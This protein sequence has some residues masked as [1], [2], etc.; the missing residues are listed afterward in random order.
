MLPQMDLSFYEKKK[1]K[2]NGAWLSRG[3]II[4]KKMAGKIDLLI[5]VYPY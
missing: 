1:K 4:E 2:K 5:R 3:K